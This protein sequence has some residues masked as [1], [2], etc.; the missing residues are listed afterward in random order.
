MNCI[1][2][3]NKVYF[4]NDFCLIASKRMRSSLRFWTD[5]H[6][7]NPEACPWPKA[8][9]EYAMHIERWYGKMVNYIV[10]IKRTRCFLVYKTSDGITWAKK[11]RK[12]AEGNEYIIVEDIKLSACDISDESEENWR[13][14]L[15]KQQQQRRY[16]LH[17]IKKLA[18][19]EEFGYVYRDNLDKVVRIEDLEAV[20]NWNNAAIY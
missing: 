8:R 9:K 4:N 3:I 13:I 5:L 18:H 2:Q 6:K 12:D 7:D 11:V 1:F 14:K 15:N 20:Y 16:E 19:L 17:F 10:P